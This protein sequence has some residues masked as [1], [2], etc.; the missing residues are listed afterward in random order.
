MINTNKFTT[1]SCV[2][3]SRLITHKQTIYHTPTVNYSVSITYIIYI[4]I[5]RLNC[6][7]CKNSPE[8]NNNPKITK[9]NKHYNSNLNFPDEH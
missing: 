5:K 3:S 2:R 4:N 7:N 8:K 9:Q 1:Q 6:K